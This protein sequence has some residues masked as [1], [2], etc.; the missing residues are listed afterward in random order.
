MY[1]EYLPKGDLFYHVL[2]IH[3]VLKIQRS[4]CEADEDEDKPGVLSWYIV[5]LSA[6]INFVHTHGY[7]FCDLKPENV[8]LGNNGYPRLI[9]FGLSKLVGPPSYDIKGTPGYLA[10]EM[11]TRTGYSTPIDWWALGALM[12]LIASGYEPFMAFYPAPYTRADIK[13]TLK[14]I[15]CHRSKRD[16]FRIYA[17]NLIH[18]SACE[19]EILQGLLSPNQNTRFGWKDIENAL[20]VDYCRNVLDGTLPPP[21][22]P[23]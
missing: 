5:Y 1:M 21:Y 12:F 6:A 19:L 9:D 7:I 15:K 3:Q 4:I 23:N 18:I 14:N 20:G 17:S 22:I 10:P 13:T 8:L 2:K 16:P 11:L